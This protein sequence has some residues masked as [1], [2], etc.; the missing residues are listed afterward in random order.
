MKIFINYKKDAHPDHSFACFLESYLKRR[1]HQVFR[2]EG[3]ILAGEEWVSRIFRE[4]ECCDVMISLVSNAALQSNWV[5]NEIDQAKKFNRRF[6]PVLLESLDAD[7]EFLFRGLFMSVQHYPASGDYQ[8]DAQAIA[9]SITGGRKLFYDQIILEAFEEFGVTNPMNLLRS[10]L[11]LLHD[12]YV[13]AI[14]AGSRFNDGLDSLTQ[15]HAIHLADSLR[16][17]AFVESSVH[18]HN[19]EVT[20]QNGQEELA[21][22]LDLTASHLRC[23]SMILSRAI[24]T[25]D[26]EGAE[27]KDKVAK[28]RKEIE[29]GQIWQK[30]AE[31]DPA[32]ED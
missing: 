11:W 8:Q 9:D 26:K 3:S 28:L 31:N 32:Q 29:S 15:M 23:I 16:N 30:R 13:S 7:R 25:W 2:D 17:I 21:R 10:L 5:L 24:E 20:R 1:G 27:K 18:K 22:G 19:A 6:V 12:H 4:I 14:W